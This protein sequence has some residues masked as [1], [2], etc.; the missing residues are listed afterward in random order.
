ALQ[1]RQAAQ[2]TA[3]TSQSTLRTIPDGDETEATRPGSSPST[4]GRA[5]ISAVTRPSRNRRR[6][7]AR[8]SAAGFGTRRGLGEGDL[9]LAV[10]GALEWLSTQGGSRASARG[11]GVKGPARTTAATPPAPCGRTRAC[12]R[13]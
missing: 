8:A 10:G 1:R 11:G 7:S 6:R 12:A 9:R 4:R 3:A 5:T 13:S 2:P